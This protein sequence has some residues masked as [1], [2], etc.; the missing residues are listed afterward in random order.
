MNPDHVTPGG[1]TPVSADTLRQQVR[2]RWVVLGFETHLVSAGGSALHV[3]MGG[4][5]QP[6][7]LL[8]GYPQSGEIWR[9]IAPE[10][11]REHRLIIP[12]LP[13][14]G[15][16]DPGTSPHTLL[17]AT[18]AIESLLESVGVSQVAV[19]GHDWGGAVG[20]MLAL[21][22]P[23]RASHLVFIES[24]LAGAGF[25]ALWRFDTPNPALAFIPLLLLQGVAERL[26]AGREQVFLHH[27][28]ETF[29][30]DKT[31]APFEAWTPYI[32]SMSRPEIF[33]SSADY[34]RSAYQSAQDTQRL[35]AAGKLA[36]P[37]LPMGGERSFGAHVESMARNFAVNVE[38]GFVCKGAGHFVPEERPEELRDAIRHFLK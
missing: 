3:A 37:V 9:K 36:I 32:A 19:V 23:D 8:H 21:A 26:V 1:S 5:G 29:T 12:D 15:C 25:E 13:G 31:A 22:R 35:L 2:D 6:L 4:A 33:T 10:L 27:L 7:L 17:L 11:A 28:W 38:P 34:Y 18:Q 30:A 14:M 24:A 16:S 20:A